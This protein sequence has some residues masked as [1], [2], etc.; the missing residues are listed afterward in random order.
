MVRKRTGKKEKVIYDYLKKYWFYGKSINGLLNNYFDCGAPGKPRK[1]TKKPGPRSADGNDFI[2]TEKDKEIFKKADK[3][4]HE[5]GGMD[6]TATHKHM[7]EKWYSSG[8]VREHGVLVPIVKPEKSPTLKQFRNWYTKEYSKY[9]KYSKSKG[10]RKAEMDVRA[11]LGNAEERANSVGALFEIDSTPADIL[12]VAEDR[13][14]ILGSPTLYMVK[15]VFSRLIAGFHITRSHA[16]SIEQMVAVEN[17]ATNKVE[18]C[19]KY[20][21]DIEESDW[22]CEHLPRELAGDRG[23]LKAKMSENMVNIRVDIANA[24]SYRGDL[25]PFIEQHFRL[26]NKKIRELFLKYGAK[27]PKLIE[28]GDK[29]PARNAVMTFYEFTQFMI[30]LILTYNKSALPENYVVTQEMFEDKVE[31]TPLGVWNW[32]QGMKLLH[33]Q[34][35]DVLRFNLLPKEGATVTRWGVKWQGMCYESPL[36]I[37]EGWF[38]EESIHG[39]KKITI[40]YDPRNVSSIFIRLKNGRLEPC[41]LTDK[42]KEYEGLHLEDVTAIM[43][44][45]KDQLNQKKKEAQQHEAVLNAFSKELAEKA[46]KETKDATKGMSY[47]ERQQGKREVRKEEARSRGSEDA[48]TSTNSQNSIRTDQKGNVVSF[49]NQDQTGEGEQQSDIQKRFSAKIN[50]R[51]RNREPM[52]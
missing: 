37:E 49:P 26:T 11:L 45:K 52:E 1:I 18:F 32:G 51:R 46:K 25:K 30:M 4:F 38:V 36:G 22:P 31:L 10:K 3:L 35:R 6:I 34:P 50:N 42:Y 12:L 16:S 40:S 9:E 7:C 44:Y 27:P 14:T 2:V 8:S 33:K 41:F 23:E 29:D 28:R 24:P 48:W 19:R 47:Y 21:I 20:G 17:T 13:K 15:D 5:E 39:E 43:K